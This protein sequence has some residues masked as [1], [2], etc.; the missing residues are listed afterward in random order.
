[1][2]AFSQLVQNVDQLNDFL[3]TSQCCA[4][5]RYLVQ[6]LSTQSRDSAVSL[7]R[8]I[9]ERLPNTHIIGHSTRHVILEGEIINHG[10]L[11]CVMEFEQTTLTSAVQHYS[12]SPDIDGYDL[13][14]A[15]Q[16]QDNSKA[17]ISF[18]V[19]IERRDYPVYRVFDAD[20]PKVS[21]G[22]AQTIDDG[23]WVL[24]QD[25]VYDEAVV[26][27]ALHSDTLKTWTSAYSEWN[28]IGMPHKVTHAKG[29]RLYRLGERK[30]LEVYKHYLADG[31][32]LT[33]NQ[34]L[35]FPLYRESI[36]RKEVCAVTEIHPDGSMS[37]D[38]PWCLGDEVQFCYNHPSLTLEQVRHGVVELSMHQ[39]E[40]VMIYN[41]ASRLDFIDSSDEV[42]AFTD[43]SHTSG[44]YCMGELY[45]ENH[46]QEILHHSLTYLAMR[47]GDEV[48]ALNMPQ[49]EVSTSI[50][51][52]FSLIRNAIGDL[53][54]MNAH[55]GYQLDRQAKKLEQSFRRDSRTGLQNRVALQERL[56]SIDT[57]EHLLTLKL[58]NFSHINEKYGYRVG[59]QL[60]KDLSMHFS[61]RLRKR[62]GKPAALQL[63]SIG[64][65]EWA[66][67]FK[68]DTSSEAIKQHFTRFADAVEQTNF[69]PSGLRDIDYLS[70]S[71][72]GGLVSRRDFPTASPDELLLKGI[73]A[74]RAGVRSN[75]HICNAKDIEVNEDVRKEQLG[76]LS[77]V[78]RAILKQNIITYSQPI[79]HAYNHRPASQECL[80]RI[81]EEDGSIIA[82]GRFLPIIS[83]THLY[84]RLSRHMIRS[85]L[86]YMQD[87][88][89]DF[90]INLSPQDLLSDKTLM[91]LEHAITQLNDP[92]R[93]GL[94][95]LES[96]QI[97]DYGRM[98]EVCSHFRSLGARI[99]VD[100]FGSGYSNIDE[101]L[102]LEPEVI[103]LDGSLIRYIDKDQKQRKIASQLVR[104]CQVFNAKTVAEFVHNKEVCDIAQD[105]GVDYLQGYYLGEPTRLF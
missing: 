35:N 54:N 79:V 28:P 57:D 46:Q 100:D 11:V 15:L 1:M 24:H 34:L 62:L 83:D 87:Q 78:S 2:R 45:G 97:K 44:S 66:F 77:C 67:L 98:I 60:L 23:C 93:I 89:G 58:L 39:P 91:L 4:D 42:R 14:Q 16:L 61:N 10:C 8:A 96:E 85:T 21:G 51:P 95:V 74:R 13:K 86:N 6:L 50:S 64:V 90:S 92:R 101:I 81:M 29:T 53:N 55:M 76:W 59:D 72:C 30:A 41:C 33:L 17:I 40:A 49:Q 104:L 18:S 68:A 99:I 37:F 80:V 43:I 56:I 22:L 75:T 12:F 38:R 105:M 32:D 84:T 47:E 82:P 7:A 102:K 5:K 70:I 69:E 103:K 9:L 88:H 63:Y 20:G 25:Q 73:E 65:G 27:V 36:G 48:T 19:Q 31:H 26:A 52:L 94:E 3:V 71:L